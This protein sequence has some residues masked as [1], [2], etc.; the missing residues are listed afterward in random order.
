MERYNGKKFYKKN[1]LNLFLKGCNCIRSIK[2][3][4]FL[5]FDHGFNKKTG[6]TLENVYQHAWI[7]GVNSNI[8]RKVMPSKT[9][10]PTIMLY[11]LRISIEFKWNLFVVINLF[12]FC[13]N[14]YILNLV[15]KKQTQV[16]FQACNFQACNKYFIR[17]LPIC[18][19]YK[20]FN[21]VESMEWLFNM[22]FP[23]IKLSVVSLQAEHCQ[24]C[25]NS[26]KSHLNPKYL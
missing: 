13:Y 23:G 18:H 5:F 20:S 10:R 16:P 19:L 7:F 3:R 11:L 15:I 26:L 1:V 8:I 6:K 25:W 24:S 21:C 4:S 9:F 2:Y 12:D 14:L 17:V 22:F